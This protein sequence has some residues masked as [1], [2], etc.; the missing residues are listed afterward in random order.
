MTTTT[1]VATTR[2]GNTVVRT[3]ATRTYTH[4]MLATKGGQAEGAMSWHGDLVN[5][6]K[7]AQTKAGHGFTTRV[8]PV[9]QAFT[10]KEARLVV[11]AA[12]APRTDVPAKAA[13]TATPTA[14]KEPAK[15]GTRTG[16]AKGPTGPE[17]RL[18]QAA[19]AVAFAQEAARAALAARDNLVAELLATKV[20]GGPSIAKIIGVTPMAVYN[21][22]ARSAKA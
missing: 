8:V 11:E 18:V 19:Q 12:K 3:S 9:E 15:A 17:E 4:V 10:G 16:K 1:F 13:P 21:M 5:A 22:R 20:L 2:E 14:A 6:T 7:A